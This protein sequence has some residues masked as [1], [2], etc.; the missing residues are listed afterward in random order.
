MTEKGEGQAWLATVAL[1]WAN[2]SCIAINAAWV[3]APIASDR[4]KSRG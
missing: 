3:Q 4:Q 2:P 1:R